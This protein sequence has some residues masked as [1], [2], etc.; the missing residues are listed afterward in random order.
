M[1]SAKRAFHMGLGKRSEN[2]IEVVPLEDDVYLDEDDE[3]Q[4]RRPDLNQF[5]MGFGKRDMDKRLSQFHMGLGK[6]AA[7]YMGLGK[8]AF[9]M[10]LGKRQFETPESYCKSRYHVRR[11]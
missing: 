4:D 5:H 11:L 7:M 10:G 1:E 9:H 8:R 6:R 2:V 3:S